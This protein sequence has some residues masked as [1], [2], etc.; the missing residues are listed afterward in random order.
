MPDRRVMEP[1]R[2]RTRIDEE[3]NDGV[4]LVLDNGV[5]IE[6][7]PLTGDIAGDYI[8]I[9]DADGNEIGY[10]N[11]EEWRDD[12]IVVMGAILIAAARG[13][14]PQ[15]DVVMGPPLSGAE[16]AERAQGVVGKN[17]SG[18]ARDGEGKPREV[19][20]Y[21]TH[22][23]LET[24]EHYEDKDLKPLTKVGPKQSGELQEF[25]ERKKK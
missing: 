11:Y 15:P 4:L 21:A 8:L 9:A 23:P 7:K 2:P 6:S 12:P 5:R 18:P 16:A 25:E 24:I 17:P 1:C 22:T 3:G 19:I 13:R 10:W 20:R 14:A